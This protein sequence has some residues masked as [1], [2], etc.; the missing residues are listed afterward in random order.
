MT[1]FWIIASF[2]LFTV[3]SSV[4]AQVDPTLVHRGLG[5]EDLASFNLTAAIERFN[6]N[7]GTPQIPQCDHDLVQR[8]LAQAYVHEAKIIGDSD[9][10]TELEGSRYPFV[11]AVGYQID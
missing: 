3:C 1:Y 2:A 7:L 8:G 4:S 5:A 6:M 11:T 9:T 10:R